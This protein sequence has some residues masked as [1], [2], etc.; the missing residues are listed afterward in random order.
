MKP[1]LIINID[2]PDLSLGV[3]FYE[4]ALG[5]RRR[6]MLFAGSVAEMECA[7]RRIFLIEQPEHSVAAPK[8]GVRRDYSTHWTPVHLDFAVDDL[9]VAVERALRAGATRSAEPTDQCF[10]RLAPM[11][12]PFGHGFCLIEF[13]ESGY[14]NAE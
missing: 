12:D 8:T 1:A 2:V 10:G 7:A 4:A 3:A 6:R 5:F 11:R 9:D 13:N 14:D